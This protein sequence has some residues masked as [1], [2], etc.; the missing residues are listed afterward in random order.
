M[1]PRRSTTRIARQ[2]LARLKGFRDIILS[3]DLEPDNLIHRIAAR[4]EHDDRR[5]PRGGQLPKEG[6]AIRVRQHEIEEDQIK[7][8]SLDRGERRGA[9]CGVR[10]IELMVAQIVRDHGGEPDVV[11]D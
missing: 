11:V 7:P 10:H 5:C 3:A 1:A 6:E 2:K 9:R 8:V 4:R